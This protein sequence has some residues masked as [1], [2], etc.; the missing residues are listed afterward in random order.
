MAREFN[1]RLEARG[2]NSLI[3]Y[4]RI[5]GVDASATLRESEAGLCPRREQL[6]KFTQGLIAWVDQ[7]STS[8]RQ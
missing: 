3:V 6:N 2:R 8:L 1:E 7:S 5:R 4:S